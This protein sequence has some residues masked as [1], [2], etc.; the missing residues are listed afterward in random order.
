M[1]D[2]MSRRC[3]VG[4][5]K[6]LDPLKVYFN[7]SDLNEFRPLRTKLDDMARRNG[8]NVSFAYKVYNRFL[9]RIDAPR[10]K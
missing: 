5:L 8:G 3:Y 1:E 9:K 4:V 6:A 10:G 7:Q 2:E